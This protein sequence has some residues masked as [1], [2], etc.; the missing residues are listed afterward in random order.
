MRH[1]SKYLYYNTFGQQRSTKK[2]DGVKR[3]V[4]PKNLQTLP[5]TH[6][7][8]KLDILHHTRNI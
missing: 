4:R 6:K 1:S 7:K 5:S 8:F 2:P 3:T